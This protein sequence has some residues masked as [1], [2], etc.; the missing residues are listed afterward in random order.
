MKKHFKILNAILLFSVALGW[1]TNLYAQVISSPKKITLLKPLDVP[2]DIAGSLIKKVSLNV[3]ISGD[4]ANLSIYDNDNI[5]LD[6]IDIPNTG[7]HQLMALV[8]FDALKKTTLKLV[9]TN[10]EVTVNKLDFQDYTSLNLPSYKDISEKAG[11][12]RVKSIKYGGPCVADIDQDGDYD[13]I[14][15][16]HNEETNKLY[17]NNGD[18]TVTK[19]D[20]NL[21]RWYMQ[22]LHGVS[23][24]DYDNDGDLD[25]MQTK[26]GGNGKA[27]S[28]PE[29]Y[30]NDN[31]RLVLSTLDAN[32]TVGARGRGAIWSDMDLDG[33]LDLMLVNAKGIQGETPQHNFYR[34]KG[35]GTFEIIH[36][37]G[38]ENA[39]AQRSLVTDLN[40]DNIDDIV[41][42]DPTN[43]I[44]LGNGDFTF[45]DASSKLPKGFVGTDK[46]MGATDIDIDN[47]GDFDLYFAR[48]DAF[49]VGNKP[50]F[51]FC[52]VHMTMDIKIRN[53]GSFELAL[54]ADKDIDLHEYDFV[55]RNGFKG[56]EFPIYL[57]K[58]KVPSYLK[59]G[60]Q[61][62][63]TQADSEGWPK[64]ISG[65]G[66]YF[67]HVGKGQWRS[68]VVINGD[69]FWNVNFS[70]SGVKNAT[71]EF[72]RLNRNPKDILLRNDGGTFVDVSNEWQIPSGG[73]QAGVTVGDFN[74]DG[75]SDLYLYRYGLIRS[76]PAD[77][78]LLNN[79]KGSFE[80]FTGHA[81]YSVEE[82][83]HG[84]MGQAFDFNLDGKLD[85][86]NGNDEYGMWYLYQ[87]E[88]DAK[89]A[90]HTTV[91][92]G[93][94][95]ISHVDAIAAEVIVETPTKTYRRRVESAGQIFSQSLLNMVHFGLGN[96]DIIKKITVKWRNGE[97]VVIKDKKANQ[98]YDTDSVDPVTVT[99]D[100]PMAEV[101]MGKTIDLTAKIEPVNANKNLTWSSSNEAV[102]KVDQQGRVTALGTKGQV[103]TITATSK[104]NGLSA[105]SSVKVV[106][107]VPFKVKAIT[108]TSDKP[109]VYTGHQ[110]TAK[111]N[112][113]P[114]DADNTNVNWLSSNEAIATVDASGVVTGVSKGEVT[115]TA[116]SVENKKVSG[117]ISL[118]VET[119][120]APGFQVVDS[121]LIRTKEFVIGQTMEITVNY[122]AGSGHT[123]VAQDLGG[124]KFWLRQFN[125]HWRSAGDYD[126]VIDSS[127]LGKES[128]TFT[129]KLNLDG[130]VPTA[131]LPEGNMYLLY[132][133]MASSNG[134]VYKMDFQPLKIVKK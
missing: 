102:L 32:I 51:D 110:V 62:I 125:S 65:N 91:R 7:T 39:D 54:A 68:A 25:I 50:S 99:I 36:V 6:N 13:F 88:L 101:R 117:S 52:P 107:L 90:N 63:I 53:A 71:P 108:V 37:E 121:A 120:R 109:V 100:L 95:P 127:A 59:K 27:P 4:Y 61:K 19:H 67:G 83:G 26:G 41:L 105:A 85:M 11:L 87:N 111:A 29:F 57:G 18:G 28:L 78:M 76:K 74:N 77:Y 46:M 34:N 44:W 130:L 10:S 42:Y 75:F 132:I 58:N 104:A 9:A 16:N 35:D 115:I 5:L 84:D 129:A 92:V 89:N 47:D 97:T 69:I 81:A 113:L 86:L 17:W 8:R 30:R 124:I 22:D 112:I 94:S 3:T 66:I 103:A 2:Y 14:V 20:Q 98:I 24:A 134:Q 1:Q 64:D 96:E 23:C 40:G 122:S 43:T 38:I 119:Y 118:N 93:Y 70:L 114:K 106:K 49:S 15:T 82:A 128:G 123:I 116:V 45:T 12:D 55:G 126:V 60:G 79:G 31:G 33:D 133:G 131:E 48:G 72:I 73:N 56:E 21:S 80:I